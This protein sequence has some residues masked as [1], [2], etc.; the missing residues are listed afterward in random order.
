MV[1]H[2]PAT[3]RLCDQRQWDCWGLAAREL[4]SK[5]N[6]RLCPDLERW[7]GLSLRWRSN[8]GLCGNILLT[9]L[10]P[11]PCNSFLAKKKKGGG[12]ACSLRLGVRFT[13]WQTANRKRTQGGLSGTNGKD[14]M[15]ALSGAPPSDRGYHCR[16][17]P[18][19]KALKS[20][21]PTPFSLLTPPQLS[22]ICKGK[23]PCSREG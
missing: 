16:E 8:P 17:S 12:S 15:Q 11:Q 5:F 21:R 1:T 6:Q 9:E 20:F 18:P 22:P 13:K 14:W 10:H 19:G 7:S 2:M 23:S 3:Q 4:S